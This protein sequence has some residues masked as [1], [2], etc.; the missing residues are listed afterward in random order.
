MLRKLLPPLI[1]GIV[2][3]AYFVL[4]REVLPRDT[5]YA[6]LLKLR[7]DA[8]EPSKVVLV[9]IDGPSLDTIGGWPW[10][11]PKLRALT[12]A[13]AQWHPRAIVLSPE[14]LKVSSDRNFWKN[15]ASGPYA[16]VLPL[17]SNK[18]I[19]EC[20]HLEKQPVLDFPVTQDGAVY[21]LCADRTAWGVDN[22]WSDPENPRLQML[23]QTPKGEVLPGLA[24]A[25]ARASLPDEASRN[26][27]HGIGPSC[28]ASDGSVFVNLS[29]GVQA[30]V[31]A[32]EL[33]SGHVVGDFFKDKIVVLG[34]TAAGIEPTFDATVAG[35]PT[36]TMLTRSEFLAVELEGLLDGSHYPLSRWADL[37]A[38]ALFLLAAL[39]VLGAGLRRCPT[40][41]M[42]SALAVCLGGLASFLAIFFTS[43]AW[44]DP[45]PALLF[46]TL[47]VGVLLYWRRFLEFQVPAPRAV[48]SSGVHL[49]EP[50]ERHSTS[51]M[52]VTT[53]KEATEVLE[54][55]RREIDRIERSPR[56]EYLKIG[57]FEQ[58]QP[59][60]QGGMCTIFQAYDPKMDRRVAI[61]ILRADKDHTE[62]NEA[63]FLREA[64][65]AGSLHHPNI[66][67]LF[68]YGRAEDL[69]YLVLEFIE[70]QTL[71]QWIKEN[72]GPRPQALLPWIRQI[73][74]ALD[75]AHKHQVIH[76][77]VK[78]SNFMIQK[79]NGLIKL[80]D[81]G[82]AHTPDATLTR[83]GTTVGTPNY[84]S[85]ELL[86]GSRVGPSADQY[87]F[88]VVVYQ[89]L[90]QR[91]PFHGEGLTA[92]CNNILRGQG[93]PLVS[94]RP[95][96]PRSLCEVVH[97]AFAVKSDERFASVTEFAEAF[98]RAV[99]E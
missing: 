39:C 1:A 60:G 54:V 7:Q 97:K 59:L 55:A 18:G 41:G 98:E 84:M 65:V 34:V 52:L 62:V 30:R 53:V 12:A 78:P 40:L 10:N 49:P 63:R 96:L 43:H 80:M 76:R 20:L 86:Q 72:P 11:L 91:V 68:E 93:T 71:S 77:D 36:G 67:T 6:S 15:F 61:K 38:V 50:K 82:V 69:W 9:A 74:S 42:V 13:V 73:A 44:V 25:A 94:L 92:L 32:R 27:L 26:L 23:F 46:P 75:L 8:P 48:R 3:L 17:Q 21:G 90:T 22:V 37:H 99:Q 57:R 89:M 5:F 19:Q 70:G 95:D 4:P 35:A 64:K 58:L 81:F 88:G 83:A 31:S 85:P 2:G 33:L 87:A 16:L 45:I 14:I 56:G 47:A 29:Q 28:F 66:N 51:S 24:I 79:E